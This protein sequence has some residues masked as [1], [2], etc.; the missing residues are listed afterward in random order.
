MVENTQNSFEWYISFFI[1]YIIPINYI[2]F[3]D[4]ILIFRSRYKTQFSLNKSCASSN[5]MLSGT[6]S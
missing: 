4:E 1:F 6:L 3:M 5:F 2:I